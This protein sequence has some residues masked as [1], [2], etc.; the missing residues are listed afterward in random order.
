MSVTVDIDQFDDD[1]ILNEA[2]H[3]GLFEP[4]NEGDLL[5][6]MAKLGVPDEV[7]R[8]VKDWLSTPVADEKKLQE[9]IK[10]S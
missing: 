5:E 4:L 7:Q 2:N 3:R 8:P 10:I 6:L 1:E 9:W